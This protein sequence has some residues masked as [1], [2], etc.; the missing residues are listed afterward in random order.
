MDFDSDSLNDVDDGLLAAGVQHPVLDCA[1]VAGHRVN[2]SWKI[3]E[4]NSMKSL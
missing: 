1:V 2:E 4:T 3:P